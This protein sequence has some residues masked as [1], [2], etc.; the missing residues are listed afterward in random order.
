MSVASVAQLLQEQGGGGGGGSVNDVIG[1]TG[2]TVTSDS[3]GDYTVDNDGILDL[4]AGSGISI[5]G[6][7]NN[8]TITNTGGGGGG[9]TSIIAGEG[10]S[11]DTDVGDVTIT[12]D[13][14]PTDYYTVTSAD[15][16]FQTLTGMG[17]YSTTAEADALYQT[18]TDMANY[19]TSTVS[20][21]LFQTIANM[22]SYSTTT[23]A[24][25]LYQTLTGMGNYSTTLQA[26]ALYA[27]IT[28]TTI[29]VVP[30]TALVATTSN[31][32]L[33]L[34]PAISP[35]S[36]I[37]VYNIHCYV[38]GYDVDGTSGDFVESATI[39]FYIKNA[40]NEST[41]VG[42]QIFTSGSTPQKHLPITLSG[43][44]N[45][46]NANSIYFIVSPVVLSSGGTQY[47]VQNGYANSL[48]QFIFT[49]IG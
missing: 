15:A 48:S 1:G 19:Y 14:N 31:T 2:I 45:I 25:A 35:A 49:R 12:S 37:Y 36:G 4:T 8:Y 18:L 5:T 27:P 34:N 42:S 29:E 21:G 22:A 32:N 16:T 33:F 3:F 41:T 26:N 10:I 39:N 46:P 30:T 11:V 9:V 47:N 40:L 6:T 20:D 44:F 13:V 17:D 24:N 28:T 23:Q 38:N 43:I 7:K